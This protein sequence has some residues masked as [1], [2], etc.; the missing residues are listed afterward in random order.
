M[1]YYTRYQLE[2]SPADAFT[3]EDAAQE[4]AD[5]ANEDL[6]WWGDIVKGWNNVKWYEY[7]DHMKTLSMNHPNM[8]FS[9]RGEGEES[10]DIWLEYFQNGQYIRHTPPEWEVPPFDAKK[11]RQW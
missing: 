6:R 1:G 4:L 7:R 2:W 8:V 10:G 3:F 9:L 5:I 11:L